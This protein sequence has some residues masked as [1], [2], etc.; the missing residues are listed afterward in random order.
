M[1]SSK[2]LS[3]VLTIVE[4]SG[5]VDEKTRDEALSTVNRICSI[6]AT[7]CESDDSSQLFRDCTS[8][9]ASSSTKGNTDFTRALSQIVAR[10]SELAEKRSAF[11]QIEA[12]VNTNKAPRTPR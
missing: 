6:I 4:E 8:R 7:L 1:L 3:E 5:D 11:I 12:N 9:I 2:V 10:A